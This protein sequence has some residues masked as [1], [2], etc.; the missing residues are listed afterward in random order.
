MEEQPMVAPNGQQGVPVPLP[1]RD[2]EDRENTRFGWNFVQNFAQAGA[3]AGAQS[4]RAAADA[5]AQAPTGVQQPAPPDNAVP[6][7]EQPAPVPDTTGGEAGNNATDAGIPQPETVPAVVPTNAGVTSAVLGEDSDAASET[8]KA[9]AAQAQTME[10]FRAEFTE[11]ISA[12]SQSLAGLQEQFRQ[13]MQY[14]EAKEAIITRQHAELQE[15]RDGLK[16][17]L[18]RPVLY[19]IVDALD[20][21]RKSKQSYESIDGGEKA[22]EALE[23]VEESLEYVL[24]KNDVERIETEPGERFVATR[25]RAVKYEDVDDTARK[26][27]IL[28]SLAPGYALGANVLY[29]EKVVVCK[30]R[31]RPAAD[32]TAQPVQ[33]SPQE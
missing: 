15:L 21:I 31:P 14:D 33:D 25:Q 18:L 29:K 24:E 10:A 23:G 12:V 16:Q 30:L 27:T 2:D 5:P 32:A 11:S 19:D 1:P 8:F 26:G 3:Q 17:D 20:D 22:V 13:R 7:F 6:A 4:A 28:R 9:L